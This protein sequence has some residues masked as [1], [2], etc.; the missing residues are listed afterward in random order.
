MQLTRQVMDDAPA[1]SSLVDAE[2]GYMIKLQEEAQ[3]ISGDGT[4]QNILGLIPQATAYSAPFVIT[5]ETPIDRIALAMLQAELAL[6]PAS[7]IV[8]HPTD[9]TKM[10]MVKNANGEY[11]LGSPTKSGPPTLWGLPVVST[12][13]IT[14]G[15][16]LVGAFDTAAQIF[17]RM[18][19]EILLSTEH[20]NNFTNN[21]VT[22]RAEERLAM[23]VKR[24]CGLDHRD[25]AVKNKLPSRAVSFRMAV[26]GGTRRA[27][28]AFDISLPE[29][30]PGRLL[31]QA[32]GAT[33]HCNKDINLN[34]AR[35][36]TS[37]HNGTVNMLA[38]GMYG[39]GK[40]IWI[41]CFA[42]R[43]SS[44]LEDM[45]KLMFV[46]NTTFR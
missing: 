28:V 7:G 14:A 27:Q 25:L 36:R 29:R 32:W 18:E 41:T 31:L 22:V 13:A 35:A 26:R 45:N 17:D 8:V 1:L 4:G 38:D 12:P 15:S 3:L 19:L 9:W 24:P 23:A 5:G 37:L 43:Y 39:V 44:L 46:Q 42:M 40:I 6:L 2:L 30:A 34:T 16:F 20:G 11:I 21:E 33:V 10:R